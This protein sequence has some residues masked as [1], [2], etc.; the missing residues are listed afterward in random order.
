MAG[1]LPHLK[2]PR[3]LPQLLEG[4]YEGAIVGVIDTGKGGV[5]WQI[6]ELRLDNGRRISVTRGIE[7]HGE[8]NTGDNVT[9]VVKNVWKRSR[10]V[11]VIERITAN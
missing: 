6:V 8:L 2:M 7:L 3:S 10:R 9:V 5:K 4:I 1:R 11:G